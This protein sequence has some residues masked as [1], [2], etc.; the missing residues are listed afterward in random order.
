MTHAYV[1]SLY[2]DCPPGRGLHC[3]SAAAKRSVEAALK[4]GDVVFHA[5][6]SNNQLDTMD[7]PLIEAGMQLTA[8]LA[9]RL[10]VAAPTVLS[11]RDVP[12]MTQAAV[13][14]LVRSGV[15]A[16]SVGVNNAATPPDGEM[17][18]LVLLFVVLF[19]VLF[20]LTLFHQCRRYFGG[21]ALTATRRSSRCGIRADTLSLPPRACATSQAR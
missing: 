18:L 17:A 1:L 12:G 10:G 2:L 21:R 6:P 7:A 9:K 11:Q 5:M 16:V 14:V 15:R 3:P 20:V 19:V 4:R 13:P 8:A